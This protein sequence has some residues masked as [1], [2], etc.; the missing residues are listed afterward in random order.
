MA[1]NFRLYI[2]EALAVGKTLTLEEEQTH[3]LKNVVKY[4]IGDTLRCFDNQ[5]GEFNC[6]ITTFNKKTATLEVLDKTKDFSACPDIWLL[7]APLKKDKTDFVIEKATEL[8]CRKICPVQTLYTITGN[9][10]LE[11]YI[12]QSIE[13]AEQSRRTDLPEILPLRA[14]TEVLQQWDSS[15]TLF[16][17]DETLQSSDFLT[18]LKEAKSKK[19]AILIGP[20]G[21]FSPEELTL[22]RNASFARGATIG[23]RILRAETAAA[24]ALSCWQLIA[25]DWSK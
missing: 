17:M 24:A 8:G 11:R 6:Q 19:A 15:R 1:K 7:F 5:N 23:P 10:K 12:A 13:A 2:K 14:L 9:V 20:E 4:N 16:F 21:G 3:Y 18:V 22:L 25:G